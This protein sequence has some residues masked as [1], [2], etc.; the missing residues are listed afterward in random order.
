MIYD[1]INTNYPQTIHK[2]S[3]R[4]NTKYSLGCREDIPKIQATSVEI[5]H[6]SNNNFNK[7]LAISINRSIYI[8]IW[9][10]LR[11]T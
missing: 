1:M 4:I 7:L 10:L 11:Q 2:I 3:T 9:T 8:T 6:A 5:Y